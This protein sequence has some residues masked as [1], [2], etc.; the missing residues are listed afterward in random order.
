M[1][2][3]C[4][5]QV[6]GVNKIP[7][8]KNYCSTKWTFLQCSSYSLY[9]VPNTVQKLKFNTKHWAAGKQQSKMFQPATKGDKSH[10]YKNFLN[11]MMYIYLFTGEMETKCC[12]MPC[13]TPPSYLPIIVYTF[14]SLEQI[15]LICVKGTDLSS[16]RFWNNFRFTPYFLKTILLCLYTLLERIE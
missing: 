16:L 14:L 12:I 6:T 3:A 11:S 1:E 5:W 10:F 2:L 4:S 13:L 15:F 8:L 7:I 9:I